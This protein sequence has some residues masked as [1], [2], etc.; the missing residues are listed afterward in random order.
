M[1]LIFGAPYRPQPDLAVDH[2]LA[3]HAEVGRFQLVPDVRVN[4]IPDLFDGPLIHDVY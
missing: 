1:L 4:E 2:L 3:R